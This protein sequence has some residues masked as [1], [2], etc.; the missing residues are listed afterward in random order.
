MDKP[1]Q[2]PAPG[3]VAR[4]A[5]AV[6]AL[7]L[8][9]APAALARCPLSLPADPAS[10]LGGEDAVERLFLGSET[11]TSGP[12]LTT[13]PEKASANVHRPA[14]EA[15]PTRITQGVQGQTPRSVEFPLP[16][17]ASRDYFLN[18]SKPMV[19]TFYWSSALAG[20]GLA[21]GF[22][23][24]VEL[25]AD[26]RRAGG[27][28][29]AYGAGG[30]QAGMTAMPICFRP[31][32]AA[33]LAGEKLSVRVTPFGGAGDF[34]VGTA[35][36]T[37]SYLGFAYFPTD[38][39]A[40]ALYVEGGALARGAIQ[41]DAGDGSERV[42][43]SAAPF[44]LGLAGLGL[45][46]RHGRAALVVALVLG[47]GFAGCLGRTAG[48]NDAPESDAP[49]ATIEQSQEP[50][51]DLN[52][53][54]AM[55]GTVR[56]AS[57]LGLPIRDAHVIVVGTSLSATTN[58]TGGFRFP[59]VTPGTF[60]MRVTHEQYRFI[61]QSVTVEAGAEAVLEISMLPV[62]GGAGKPHT[63]DLWPPE[64]TMTIFDK[65][66]LMKNP[67]YP[68]LVGQATDPQGRWFCQTSCPRPIPM[69]DSKPVLPGTVRVEVTLSWDPAAPGAPKEFGLGVVTTKE[70]GLGLTQSVV[71]KYVPRAPNDPF[72]IAIFPDE[73]DPGHQTFT[74]WVITA[75]PGQGNAATPGDAPAVAAGQSVRAKVTIHKGVVPFE[76][77]HR[78]FWD[79]ASER[80]LFKDVKITSSWAGP[81]L[82]CGELPGYYQ[83]GGG[84]LFVP[85]GTLEIRG[86]MSWTNP[87]GAPA[88]NPAVWG[89][90]YRPANVPPSAD[91]PWKAVQVTPKTATSVDF[92][93]R[94][95]AE[96]TDQ[97]YQKA[98]NWAFSPD[99]KDFPVKYAHTGLSGAS[100]TLSAVAYRDPAYEEESP[101][102]G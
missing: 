43:P 37:R 24:R 16:A 90:A 47:A 36:A 15:S 2:G 101:L 88:S 70:F 44:V 17:G 57:A 78:T 60:T 21:D 10:L 83:W 65:A 41:A 52:A 14:L 64:G 48:P 89:L 7:L 80:L 22:K 11:E 27:F 55:R 40:G 46:R 1:G 49:Q 100:W 50:R 13:D 12:F 54:G 77:L 53:S 32:A 29:R 34:A 68:H 92:V 61:E 102:D 82:G 4:S 85:P 59:S 28:E 97:F 91:N 95:T 33:F 63:H 74:S 42:G 87:G 71:Q 5:L 8:I 31:E 38:P 26:G 6:A 20:Q 99:D 84:Q 25:L 58:Q 35:G 86:T 51:A 18:L 94:P 9:L 62:S 98:T 69:E 66:F 67:V 30:P 76:P 39:L 3:R 93:L 45:L 75:I 56:D 73:A 72:R 23:V 79:G 81:P 96:E 19:G